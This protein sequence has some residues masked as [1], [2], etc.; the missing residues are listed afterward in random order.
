MSIDLI[1]AAKD[2]DLD[3][4]KQLLT[5]PFEYHGIYRCR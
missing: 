5:N 4:V 2:G 1:N 3:K